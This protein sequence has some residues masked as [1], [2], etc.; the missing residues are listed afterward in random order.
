MGFEEISS[1]KTT[2]LRAHI[3]TGVLY[4]LLA[5]QFSDPER[6]LED[7]RLHG[8]QWDEDPTKTRILI[9][10]VYKWNVKNVQQRPG[11]LVKRG[12]I[13]PQKLG[14]AHGF[15]A[16][17]NRGAR[18]SVLYAGSHTIFCIGKNGAE[19]DLIGQE[20]FRNLVEFSPVILEDLDFHR[21][22]PNELGAVAELE[23]S[24]EHFVAPVTIEWIYEQPWRLQTEAPWLKGLL[25]QG[26][27]V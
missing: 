14:I 17:P 11:L 22:M 20:V 1:L 4:R 5:Q 16:H 21:F 12:S 10:P 27:S 19:V 3:L 7:S 6:N 15:G 23:E 13:R 2:T 18:K 8:Y 9:D 25:L 24:A 26:E